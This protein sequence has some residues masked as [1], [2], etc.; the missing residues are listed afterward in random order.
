MWIDVILPLAISNTY[1]YYVPEEL[2]AGISIGIRVEAPIR[3]KH[4]T[5]IVKSMGD[6]QP[7]YNARPI[8]SVLDDYPVVTPE[9]IKLWS[10]MAD[11][12]CCT[13]GE[14]MNVAMPS[15]LKLSSET[16]ICLNPYQLTKRPDKL[17]RKEYLLYET[18]EHQKEISVDKL[19]KLLGQK[20]VY[21]FLKTQM[22]QK[23]II[24]REE[25]QQKYKPKYEDYIR[26]HQH[27]IDS[28]NTD[29]LFAKL[30]R[31]E[32]QQNTLLKIVE[33]HEEYEWIPKFKLYKLLSIDNAVIKALERKGMIE[34]R[35]K[36][37][38]RIKLEH[39]QKKG[40]KSLS[41][42]Q[43]TASDSIYKCFED[44]NV[45]LLQGVTGSGKTQIYIHHIKEIIE[46]GGQVLYMLPEIALTSQMLTRLQEAFGSEVIFYHSRMTNHEQ[47]E[48]WKRILEGHP[49]VLGARS[50]LLLPYQNLQ[51][52][53]VDE[54]HDGSYKQQ[55]PSPRYNARDVATYLSHLYGAKVMLGTA[56]PALDTVY[57]KLK[58]KYGYVSIT[59]RFGEAV[60][61]DIHIVDLNEEKEVKK[62]QVIFSERLLNSIRQK[63]EHGEQVLLFQNRRGFA[64]TVKCFKCGVAV[65]CPNCDVSLTL[66]QFTKEMRCHYCGFRSSI[67]NSCL[68]CGNTN[69]TKLGFGTE[70]IEDLLS[71]VFPEFNIRRLDH[72]TVRSKTSY[73]EILSQME[74]GRIDILI[75][76]QMITKGLDFSNITL[77]GILHA[78]ALFSF[79]DFRA[80]EK[81]FQLLTQVSGRAGRSKG[82]TE[83]LIQTYDPDNWI[84]KK[85][86]EYDFSSFASKEL[87]ERQMFHYPP[88]SRL[89]KL[90]VKHKYRSTAKEAASLL[91][92]WLKG[93]Y[94]KRVL[95]PAE[96]GIARINNQYHFDILLKIEKQSS[97]INHIKKNVLNFKQEISKKKGLSTVRLIINVD[98]L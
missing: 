46:S 52:I 3:N 56:T 47:V 31:S 17:S 18:L 21:A 54:E 80:G 97:V 60:L 1:T 26:A 19:K 24:T 92:H 12:Y 83:V 82:K 8:I 68:S 22:Q 76:T 85:V 42:I 34:I 39:I 23:I 61:P 57:N 13:I 50:S 62:G 11:Y 65:Q 78:D 2:Q 41:Q 16:Q 29:D 94:G 4:Y 71:E 30:S 9:Q 66:H 90:T 10:W 98:P 64:P 32:K 96:P 59:E 35:K 44:Q 55:D 67:S 72:D 69:L 87:S 91:G 20:S 38:N 86:L 75:G 73:N 53:I 15:G 40:L 77:V 70:R 27:V 48:V 51:L 43:Q 89:I 63:V 84:I 93:D 88:F 33:L 74:V 58:G 95:G 45:V 25:L 79:P 36:E 14:V 81:A 5:G 28:E 37:I 6:Q 7:D 49:I